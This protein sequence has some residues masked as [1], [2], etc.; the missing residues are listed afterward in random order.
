MLAIAMRGARSTARDMR[1]LRGELGTWRRRLIAATALVCGCGSILGLSAPQPDAQTRARSAIASG[2]SS[3]GAAIARGRD[4]FVIGCSSCHALNA[5]GVA[6]RGPSL[7]GVGAAAADFYLSTGRMPLADPRQEPERTKPAYGR[8][9]IAA[10]DAY[11][12]SLGGPPIPAVDPAAGSIRRGLNAYTLNC[13]GCHQIAGAGGI[14]IDFVA[15]SLTDATAVQVAEAVRIGPYLM[16]S[17]GPR[18]IPQSDLDSI[19]RYVLHDVRHPADAGGWSIG[20]LGPVPEGMVAW[21][22]A[23]AALVLVARLIGERAE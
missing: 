14:G 5:T 10:L 15:P 8:A 19:A 9:D 17:F 18:Q 3:S 2:G 12:G 13:A 16:P 4:L 22:L 21:L 23:G 11:V 6:G 7:I 1:L 20:H